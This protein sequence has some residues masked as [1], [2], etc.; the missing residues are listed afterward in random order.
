MPVSFYPFRTENPAL[1]TI[2][3]PNKPSRLKRSL[4]CSKRMP[5]GRIGDKRISSG[6]PLNFRVTNQDL[7]NVSLSLPLSAFSPMYRSKG[8][9]QNRSRPF[10]QSADSNFLT[11]YFPY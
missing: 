11:S 4:E 2:P 3:V 5:R 1:N 8:S 6:N 10:Q 7:L 9:L